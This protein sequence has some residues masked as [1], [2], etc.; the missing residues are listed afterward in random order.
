MYFSNPPRPDNA[1]KRTNWKTAFAELLANPALSKRDREIIESLQAHWKRGK[2][3]SRGR[4][5]YFYLI[6]DRT[7]KAAAI[8]AERAAGAPTTMSQRLQALNG[9]IQDRSSWD[10]GFVESLIQQEASR[11]LSPRQVEVLEKIESRHTDE[12]LAERLAWAN[13][14]Y[15]AAE[16]ERMRVACTY[17]RLSG[18]YYRTIVSRFFDEG[19]D[20]IPTKD[21][22]DKVV[23]NKYSTK[24]IK[25]WEAAPKYPAGTLVQVRSTAPYS[26]LRQP[27]LT[28]YLQI[29]TLCVVIGTSEP[30]VSA[31]KGCKRYKVLPVGSTEFYLVEERDIKI[32]R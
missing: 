30:I 9:R 31:A 3:L 4:K 7:E 26:R 22:Y 15:G 21:E 24:V 1:P 27:S 5:S 16:H 19:E 18:Q 25:A 23:N 29:G 14:G 17:Y 8:A 6:K 13:G 32:R 20:Y 28:S 12:L 11:D 10:A 2:S